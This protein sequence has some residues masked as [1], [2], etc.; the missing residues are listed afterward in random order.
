MLFCQPLEFRVGSDLGLHLCRLG[1]SKLAIEPG[2]EFVVVVVHASPTIANSAVRPRTS[3]L[4]TVPIGRPSI[5]ET[6]R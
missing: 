5:S 1:W 3:R 4:D 6:S 2:K